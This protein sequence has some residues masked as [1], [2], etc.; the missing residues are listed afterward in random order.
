MTHIPPSLQL[1]PRLGGLIDLLQD[2]AANHG[3]QTAFGPDAGIRSSK[4]QWDLFRRGRKQV[5]SIWVPADPVRRVGIV[6]NA[7]PEHAPHCCHVDHDTTRGSAACDIWVVINEK[8]ALRVG[9]PG[10]GSYVDLGHLGEQLGL[11]WG[12]RFKTIPGGDL[13]HFELAEFRELI[14]CET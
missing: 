13:D 14:P 9:D 11:V 1:L 3:I 10:Y 12:G 5:G 4:R 6:T 8:P 2:Q 7:T